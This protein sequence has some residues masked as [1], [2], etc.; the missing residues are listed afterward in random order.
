MGDKSSKI[1]NGS[2][3]NNS[4][5]EFFGVLGDFSKGSGRDSLKS[6]L[7]LLDTENEE[8]NSSGID[9]SLSELVVVF[10]DARKSKGSS[11]FNRWIEFLE[12]V[13]KGIKST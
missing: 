1:W 10:S 7:W 6:K 12:A 11:F 4:L 2:L 8:T 3:I 9:N 5:S 13:N